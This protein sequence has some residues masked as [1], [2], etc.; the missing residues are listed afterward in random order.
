MRLGIMQPY[1]FPYLGYFSLIAATDQF[2]VF[3]PVQ[4]I[5]H[6]WINRNRILKPGGAEPQ[7]INVPL[8]KHSRETLIQN[9]KIANQVDWKS[10]ILG[11]IQHYRKRAPYFFQTK[12]IL[13][14]CFSLETDS[15]V[16]LNVHCLATVCRSLDLEFNVLRYAEIENE[17]EPVNHPGEWALH[18]SS[19]LHATAYVNPI[20][21]RDIFQPAQFQERGMSL[22]FLDPSLTPYPQRNP[23][24][25]PGL[26]IIDVLMFN[27][28][29]ETVRQINDYV[30]VKA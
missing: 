22:M 12:Q 25:V 28:P 9:I 29:E 26:S 3:D 17:I 20:G 4:T 15:V 8:A 1:F 10:R 5:R 6:G 14:E 27:S 21:G 30:I 11:Q 13:E 23:N 24:F 2:V 7:Y 18:I 16:D 19:A